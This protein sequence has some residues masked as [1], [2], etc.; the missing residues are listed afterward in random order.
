M[1]F[2]ALLN[3]AQIRCAR[4]QK[5]KKAKRAMASCRDHDRH[6]NSQYIKSETYSLMSLRGSLE[7]ST[8]EYWPNNH[9]QYTATKYELNDKSEAAYAQTTFN[10]WVDLKTARLA[11]TDRWPD[12]SEKLNWDYQGMIIN[13]SISAGAISLRPVIGFM[14]I[15]NS[16]PSSYSSIDG[17]SVCFKVLQPWVQLHLNRRSESRSKINYISQLR[18]I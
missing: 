6:E 16:A 13:Q 18:I 11:W 5:K 12:L 15:I 10:I 9:K 4:P 14:T 7:C 1:D 2:K 17:H 8:I 3:L